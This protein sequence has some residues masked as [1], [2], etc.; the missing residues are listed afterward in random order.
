M[1][2]TIINAIAIVAGSLVGLLFKKGLAKRY[3]QAI[4]T[5]AGIVS[6]VVGIQMAVKTSHVLA[7]AI[8][9]ILGGLLGTALDIEGAV[10]RLGEGLKRRFAKDEEGGS[11]ALG[12]LNASVLYCSGA[13]AIVGSFKAGTEHDYALILTKSVLD[14][15]LSILFASAM[16][17]GVAF[18]AL[19]VLAYQGILT[20]VSVW[21]KPYVSPL[22]LGELTG[23][24][25]AL[26][27]MIGIN[28]LELKKLKTGDF[29][30]G[31]VFTVLLV[32]AMPFASFL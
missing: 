31:L 3:E 32:L 2:A 27:I 24:G 22:M 13:M 5:A 25:G 6:L 11:F 12:F 1:L 20:L 9:L 19:S 10:F 29:L 26:V 16:G 4:F 14:G 7:F 18:S 28:L 8:A 17:V 23:I 15:L 30:P 21:V